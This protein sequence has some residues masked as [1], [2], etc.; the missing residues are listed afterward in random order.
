DMCG[1]N[2]ADLALKSDVVSEAPI[3]IGELR[4][5]E[6]LADLAYRY[7]GGRLRELWAAL[8]LGRVKSLLG[9]AAR[10]EAEE[11]TG[12]ALALADEIG[13]RWGLAAASLAAAELAA[14][15]GDRRA[16]RELCQ[17]ALGLAQE[18]G[19]VR[20]ARRAERLPAADRGES[21]SGAGVAS[22]GG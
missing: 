18:M 17:R 16:S 7:A 4:R 3:A 8:A 6:H 20:L 14:E 1:A 9:H 21:A 22:S 12:R 5:A 15:R 11:W 13:S 2:P 10:K 19:L